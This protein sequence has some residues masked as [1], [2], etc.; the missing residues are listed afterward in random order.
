MF[1]DTESPIMRA[2]HGMKPRDDEV[3]L[4][5]QWLVSGESSGPMDGSI[6]I[7][8]TKM[9]AG[10]DKY[11]NLSDLLYNG[12]RTYISQRALT[13]KQLNSMSD[14]EAQHHYAL[15][16]DMDDIPGGG[17]YKR[18]VT[19]GRKVQHDR[20]GGRSS[21]GGLKKGAGPFFKKGGKKGIY[22]GRDTTPMPYELIDKRYHDP[23]AGWAALKMMANGDASFGNYK[24]MTYYNR[25]YGAFFYNQNVRNGMKP[26]TVQAFKDYVTGCVHRGLLLSMDRLYS[27][28]RATE[29]MMEL[30]SRT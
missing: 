26:E 22:M 28:G 19:A 30:I 1:Y 25:Y 8:N 10:R 3:H 11:W 13:I 21:F 29:E 5:D 23:R 15:H 17:H 7:D 6:I 14:E 18:F 24:K 27:D 4:M 16:P 9:V 12:T 20:G 2:L